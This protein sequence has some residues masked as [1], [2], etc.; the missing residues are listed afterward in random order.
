MS[1]LEVSASHEASRPEAPTTP[2][3]VSRSV[4]E[5][6]TDHQIAAEHAMVR[7]SIIGFFVSIPIAMAVLIGM[8]WVAM[9][10]SQPWYVWVG[11][12]AGMGF[13]AAGFLGTT[14]GVLLSA[15]RLN[16]IAGGSFL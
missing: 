15:R 10:D 16:R 3:V 8:M 11:F 5:I 6:D 13:Y 4:V 1:R 2:P 12:G 7:V 9:G 14:A